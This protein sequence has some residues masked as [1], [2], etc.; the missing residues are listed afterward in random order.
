MANYEH[1]NIYKEAYI[2]LRVLFS[3]VS[4]FDKNYRSIMW[5]RLLD[6]STNIVSLIVKI[7]WEQLEKRKELFNI[8]REKIDN[9]NLYMRISNDLKLFK[10]E[11]FYTENLWRVVKIRK[12]MECWD[13]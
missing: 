2:L 6:I 9:L 13:K 3:V 8:L 5:Y 4:W 7:N 10:K 12:M 11:T 1:L